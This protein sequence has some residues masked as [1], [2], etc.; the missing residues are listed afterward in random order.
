VEGLL[1]QKKS[2]VGHRVKEMV[3]SF[4]GWQW[5]TLTR[6][7]ISGLRGGQ[8]LMPLK[9]FLAGPD[10]FSGNL[11]ETAGVLSGVK[12]WSGEPDRVPSQF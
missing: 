3:S 6:K 10:G 12:Y 8:P 9:L 2:E 1:S 4:Y 7:E 11:L 5:M